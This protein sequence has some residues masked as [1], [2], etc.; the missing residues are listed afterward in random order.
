[1]EYREE[2]GD[3][4]NG[5]DQDAEGVEEPGADQ[6]EQHGGEGQRGGQQRTC[7][8]GGKE[9][10]EI[11]FN[12]AELA[13]DEVAEQREAAG[14]HR[15]EHTHDD[16]RPCGEAEAPAESIDQR[17]KEAGDN[18]DGHADDSAH[19]ILFLHGGLDRGDG[20]LDKAQELL[21]KVRNCL[22][23]GAGLLR[24]RR[25]L[26]GRGSLVLRGLILRRLVLRLLRDPVLR[27]RLSLRRFRVYGLL[28]RAGADAVLGQRPSAFCAEIC[29]NDLLLFPA[30]DAPR[31]Y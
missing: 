19:Q 18:G 17:R 29:H 14:D 11:R 30:A 20:I 13:H 16:P 4:P 10:L 31:D 26:N 24:R 9:T 6:Q 7:A 28:Q 1:M 23:K 12:L 27:F 8:D 25:R 21:G 15:G 5:D 2:S 22:A 3:D